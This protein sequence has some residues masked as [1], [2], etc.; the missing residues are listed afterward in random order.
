LQH[1]CI[2]SSHK[3]YISHNALLWLAICSAACAGKQQH[4]E[5]V[6]VFTQQHLNSNMQDSRILFLFH[7]CGQE[8]Q[9]Q[10]LFSLT[11]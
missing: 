1:Q 7:L 4:H 6:V 11:S 8:W 9:I 10:G 5:T 3:Q 2:Q